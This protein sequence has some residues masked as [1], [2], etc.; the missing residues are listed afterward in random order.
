LYCKWFELAWEGTRFLDLVRWGDAP[1]ALHFKANDPTPYLDDE[2]YVDG[3]NST[4]G[5]K[6]KA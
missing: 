2:F 4:P 6:R 5:M 3:S 1:T